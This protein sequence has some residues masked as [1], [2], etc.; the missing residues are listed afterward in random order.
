MLNKREHHFSQPKLELYGL[1]QALQLL[2]LYLIR[3]RNLVIE[4]DARY[5]D[6]MLQNLDISPS[7]SMNRWI[8]T[9]L[10]FHFNLVHVPGTNHMPDRLSR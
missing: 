2:K 6:G 9:I 3:V 1:Y 4:V 10:M 5:I 7:A 8:L